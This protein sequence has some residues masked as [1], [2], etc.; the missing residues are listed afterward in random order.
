MK[1]CSLPC[2]VINESEDTRYPSFVIKHQKECVNYMKPACKLTETN[3]NVFALA[4][5]VTRVLKKNELAEQAK[6]FNT[7]LWKCES[8]AA[9]LAL[10]TEYVEVE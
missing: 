10:M 5:Q 3:G 7:K 2:P 8:Y 9:A 1:I 4:A 6:E